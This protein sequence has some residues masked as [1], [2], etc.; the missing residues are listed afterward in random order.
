MRLQGT[1]IEEFHEDDEDG[2]ALLTWQQ[3]AENNF[4]TFESVIEEFKMVEPEDEEDKLPDQLL[5]VA[6]TILRISLGIKVNLPSLLSSR[7]TKS[8]SL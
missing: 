3:I 4:V 5:E 1:V 2:L 7:I 8:F 6:D